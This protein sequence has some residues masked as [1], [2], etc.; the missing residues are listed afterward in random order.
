MS[1]PMHSLLLVNEAIKIAEPAGKLRTIAM[2][3][4][5]NRTDNWQVEVARR[6]QDIRRLDEE[7]VGSRPWFFSRVSSALPLGC[8]SATST[9]ALRHFP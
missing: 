2:E 3:R 8:G 1:R 4:G 5:I 6:K 7:V 9:Y